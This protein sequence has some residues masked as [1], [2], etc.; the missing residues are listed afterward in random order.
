[1]EKV[2]REYLNSHIIAYTKIISEK[3]ER[4]EWL[5]VINFGINFQNDDNINP[6]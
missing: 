2:L 3:T 5:C 1:M 4:K 6:P